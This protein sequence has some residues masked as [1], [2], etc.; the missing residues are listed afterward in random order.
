MA[1]KQ[2]GVALLGLGLA[3]AHY[4]TSQDGRTITAALSDTG[5]T[6][7]PP[8][9]AH[10]AFLRFG[11]IL[12]GIIGMT[13]AAGASDT[14]GTLFVWFLVLLWVMWGMANLTPGSG[15]FASGRAKTPSTAKGGSRTFKY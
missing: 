1:G 6:A 4:H 11:G 15:L 2:T 7:P 14:A 3:A 5:V 12:A 8:Q 10:G 9:E 13:I